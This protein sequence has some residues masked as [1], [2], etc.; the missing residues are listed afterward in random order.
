M[1]LLLN[2]S[3]HLQA[4]FPLLML[5]LSTCRGCT[6]SLCMHRHG[7]QLLVAAGLELHHEDL[8]SP[9]DL[10]RTTVEERS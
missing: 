6:S 10:C 9:Q 4:P 1:I 7:W 2:R 5:F 3:H 8:L